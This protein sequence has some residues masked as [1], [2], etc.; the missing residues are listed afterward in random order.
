MTFDEREIA[1]NVV[2]IE[3]TKWFVTFQSKFLV[4][5]TTK[6]S[7]D[8]GNYFRP[9]LYIDRVLR[10]REVII[11]QTTLVLV[12][13]CL[14]CLECS[15]FVFAFGAGA[16]ENGPKCIGTQTQILYHPDYLP[17]MQSGSTGALVQAH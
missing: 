10:V 12:R 14:V 5:N 13:V 11:I 1:I 16:N 2:G 17:K 9:T 4:Y 6:A 15:V 8:L 7:T 3:K